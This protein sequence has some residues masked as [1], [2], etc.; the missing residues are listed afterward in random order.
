MVLWLTFAASLVAI[1]AATVIVVVRGVRLWR[2]ARTVGGRLSSELDQIAAASNEIQT[3]IDAADASA[4]RLREASERLSRSRARLEV[5]L[6]AL[7][8][9]RT[10]LRRL[11]PSS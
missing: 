3:H 1:I 9:A 4:N 8:E 5:Q 10:L 2:I 11:R 6:E 7:R